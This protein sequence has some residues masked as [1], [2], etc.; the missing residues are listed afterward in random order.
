MGASFSCSSHLAAHVGGNRRL[1]WLTALTSTQMATAR[2]PGLDDVLS[3]NVADDKQPRP[4]PNWLRQRVEAIVPGHGH[5]DPAP[6]A[7][8]AGWCSRNPG[9]QAGNLIREAVVL[10]VTQETRRL[11]G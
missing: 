1:N 9:R 8:G 3:V 7:R 2:H 10:A 11:H 4:F 6:A 5:N